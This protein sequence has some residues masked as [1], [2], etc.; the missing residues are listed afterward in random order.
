ML[1][2][3]RTL[4]QLM[5]PGR[6]ATHRERLDDFYDRQAGDYDRFRERLLSNR[7]EL[8]ADLEIHPGRRLLEVGG[9]TARNLEFLGEQISVLEQV[10]VLDL[11]QPLLDRAQE[12][13]DRLGWGNVETCTAD[14]T[15]WRAEAPY[16]IITCSYSLSMIPDWFAAIDN[17]INNLAP[18]GQFAVVDFYRSRKHPDTG[19]R[20][21]GYLRRHF[22]SWWFSHD[23]VHLRDDLV[24]YLRHR[25]T[26][27]QITETL[28]R[29]PYVP[30]KV[31][32]VRLIG[33]KPA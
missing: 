31:P 11:C 12:R 7:A 4:R 6:G 32:V 16:H 13:I 29:V 2:D 22:W 20:K 15:T 25:L 17:A 28:A 30:G 23:G 8:Y 26:D 14:A 27:C 21:H 1:S 10:T 9:G 3:L 18:G 33:R 5:R 19:L 24:P